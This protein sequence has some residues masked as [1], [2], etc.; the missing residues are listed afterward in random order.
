VSVRE[1]DGGTQGQTLGNN[2]S[3]LRRFWVSLLKRHP[4]NDRLRGKMLRRRRNPDFLT[5]VLTLQ[6]I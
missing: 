6:R 2:L 1:D 3:R 4:A 5:E